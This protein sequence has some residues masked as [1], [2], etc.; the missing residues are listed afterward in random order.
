RTDRPI[1]DI[2]TRSLASWAA[3]RAPP[4]AT[5]PRRRAWLRIFV[6]RCGVPCDPLVGGHSCNGGMIPRFHRLP[7]SADQAS[8]FNHLVGAGEPRRRHVEAERFG[9]LE[10]DDQLSTPSSSSARRSRSK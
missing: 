10:V 8:L 4:A 9:G 1:G 6:V 2:K 5:P 7:E 3:A